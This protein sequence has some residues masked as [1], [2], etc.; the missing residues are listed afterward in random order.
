MLHSRGH[1]VV[2]FDGPVLELM[3]AGRTRLDPH[4]AELGPDVLAD[5]FDR[6][7]F[8]TRLRSDDPTRGIGDALLDQRNVAG[9]G[10]AWKAEGCWAAAVDPWRT[11]ASVSDAEAA[12]RLALLELALLVEPP[13]ARRPRAGLVVASVPP[14]AAGTPVACRIW[15]MM[16]AFLV[17]VVVLIYIACAMAWSSSRSLPSSTDRSSCCSAVIGLLSG[18]EPQ[19]V[20]Q[21]NDHSST[22]DKKWEAACTNRL[23]PP[24]RL[25]R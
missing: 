2:E 6:A 9:I 20:G 13:D 17:R 5:E 22:A 10:N 8:L 25:L 16:S 15:S 24:R 12:P 7:R 4:L 19:R 1:E 23:I 18:T 14:S 3:T 21:E 11:L